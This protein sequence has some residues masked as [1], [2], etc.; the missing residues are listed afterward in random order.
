[1]CSSLPSFFPFV[2]I[3]L[4]PC[5]HCFSFEAASFICSLV[6]FFL[7]TTLVLPFSIQHGKGLFSFSGFFQIFSLISFVYTA[8]SISLTMFSFLLLCL[9]HVFLMQKLIYIFL[10]IFIHSLILSMERTWWISY[11]CQFLL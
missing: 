4:S 2:I 9:L 5:S 3:F 10:Y 6:I 1:M 8:F 11:V 7:R